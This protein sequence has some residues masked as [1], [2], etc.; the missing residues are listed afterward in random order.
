MGCMMRRE[1]CEEILSPEVWAAE[2][3]SMGRLR[4]EGVAPQHE[5]EIGSKHS[6]SE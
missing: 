1:S 4:D 3:L 2:C 6:I 5:N